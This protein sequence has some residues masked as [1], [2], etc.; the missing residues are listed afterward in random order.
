MTAYLSQWNFAVGEK[1]QCLEKGKPVA[2]PHTWNTQDTLE[3]YMG[4]G[5]YSCKINPCPSGKERTFLHFHGAYRDTE[6]F[7]NG[8]PA[9]THKG[10]GYTPFTME[11]TSQMNASAPSELMVSVDNRF[12]ENALPYN[13]SFDWA[14]DGGL[15]RPVECRQT[16]R[17]AIMDTCVTAEPVIL[18]T[19]KRQN[20]GNGIFGFCPIMDGAKGNDTLAWALYFGAEGSLVPKGSTP[21][22][23][24]TLKPGEALVPHLLSGISFWHFD[25]PVLYTLQLAALCADGTLSDEKEIVFGF[26]EMKIQGDGWF[27]NG[28]RVRL[29][30]MEWMPGSDPAT[31]MAESRE[32]MEAWLTRLKESNSILTRFHWQQD[33][34]V[35][36]WCDRHGMLVQEEIPFWGKQPEGDPE[37][38]WPV[39]CIHLTEMVHAHRHHPSI[40]AWGVGNELSGQK[41]SVQRYV[42]RACAFVHSLDS[43]RPVSYVTN[44]AWQC[45]FQDATKD[46]DILCINDYIGTWHTGLDQE[47][48]WET[49]LSAHPGR[50]FVPSEF[51]LCEPAF[52]GGDQARERI[53]LEK[54]ASY[55]PKDAIAG[56]VYFCLNDY[57]THMGE[58]GT[59]RFRQRVH[60]SMDMTGHKKPS[61]DTVKQTYS[62]LTARWTSDGLHI[63]CRK[64]IPCYTVEGYTLVIGDT[65]RLLPTLCPG[66]DWLY[67][68]FHPGEKISIRRPSGDH[69]IDV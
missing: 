26:R 65:V 25:R 15:I 12:S 29:P 40:I 35:Y 3:T 8:Y 7:V 28:E 56:T 62:P 2:V 68:S 69:V 45:P 55:R 46:G 53:F 37:A 21:L 36:D 61:Y 38:L 48:A 9:G 49:L 33:D 57:R 24:G 27:F 51:G 42:R 10:S 47:I 58:E 59:G 4:K 32:D 52:S 34:W 39:T 63:S 31:G 50:A 41:E 19:G 22:D 54:L 17:I 20:E 60:G 44:T 6:V 66:E 14:H 30:G 5:F 13:K 43:T 16:G 23:S 64:D 18:P 1:A 11:I 67:S